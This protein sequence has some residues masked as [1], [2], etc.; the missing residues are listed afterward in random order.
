VDEH[1]D[2][3]EHLRRAGRDESHQVRVDRA[4][5]RRNRARVLETVTR[6]LATRTPEE[7]SMEEVAR[8]AD[9]G[10][11]TLYRHYPN[12][13]CLLGA[14]IGDIAERVTANMRELIPPEASAPDKIRA[15]VS[16]LY[17]AYEEY[18]ISMELFL[19]ARLGGS[20]AQ[21]YPV[22]PLISRLRDILAQGVREGSFRP[23]NLDYTAFAVFSLISPT[24]FLKQRERL[25]Y[26]RPFQEAQ[27]VEMLWHA[28]RA[29]ITPATPGS[30]MV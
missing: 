13:E 1:Y 29:D 19:W 2:H 17:D 22:A 28:L 14:L 24:T 4:D 16:L 8:E 3:M 30:T 10:K 27:T 15:M 5:A 23:L 7:L 12:K 20:G 26:E 6:L 18:G 25:G 21:D 9:I 11:G